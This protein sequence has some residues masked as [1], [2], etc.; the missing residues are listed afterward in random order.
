MGSEDIQK[1][2]LEWEGVLVA[3]ETNVEGKIDDYSDGRHTR[4]GRTDGAP[5]IFDL[6]TSLRQ[7]NIQEQLCTAMPQLAELIKSEPATQGYQWKVSDYVELYL[8][9]YRLVIQK[10]KETISN[11][12]S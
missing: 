1:L 8:Q 7:K 9:H 3:T 5:V 12:N 2:L 4:I 11:V 10:I 6:T